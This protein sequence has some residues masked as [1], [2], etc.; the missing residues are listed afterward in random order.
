MSG[1][2]KLQRSRKAN[3]F[4]AENE[5]WET[6]QLGASSEHA[7]R[8]SAEADKA[9][10]DAIGLQLLT[11]R[12]QKP[13]VDKLRRLATLEGI[14]YQP[15]MRQVL[16]KYVHDNEHR[17]QPMLTPKEASKQAEQLFTTAIKYKDMISTLPPMTNERFDAECHYSTSL[18]TANELYCQ[19]NEKCLDPILK[20]HLKLRLKQIGA[21]LN[22]AI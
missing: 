2:R 20:K 6:R 4:D 1:T 9:L 18:G 19:A 5:L 17:L 10:D 13:V 8:T 7:V 16:T 14:G 3:Q 15:L 11:F 21:L 22:A 12:I